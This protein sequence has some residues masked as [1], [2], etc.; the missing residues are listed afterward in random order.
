MR[1]KGE[2]GL[3]KKKP[4]VWKMKK[5]LGKKNKFLAHAR[6]APAEGE[7]H[8]F[9]PSIFHFFHTKG[10]FSPDP[11]SFFPH[12]ISKFRVRHETR[13]GVQGMPHP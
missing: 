2:R 5:T 9:V 1:G 10:A 7:E 3:G 11:L 12:G 13:C 8:I 6:A 4:F